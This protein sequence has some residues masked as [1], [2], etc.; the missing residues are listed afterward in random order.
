MRP[1]Q[2]PGHKYRFADGADVLGAELLGALVRD[3]LPLQGAPV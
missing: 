2:I 3:D 1:L